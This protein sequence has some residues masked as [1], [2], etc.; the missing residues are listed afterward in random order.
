MHVL[1]AQALLNNKLRSQPALLMDGRYGPKT[2]N[3][4]GQL[5]RDCALPVTRTVGRAEWLVLLCNSA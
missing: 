4:V 5:Q 2:A 3:R 1:A